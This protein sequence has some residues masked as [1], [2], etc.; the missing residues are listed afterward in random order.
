MKLLCLA[1]CLL[2]AAGSSAFA[3]LTGTNPLVR[4]HTDLGDMDVYLVQ[5]VAP[6]TVTNFLK[7]VNRGDYNNTF[8][9]RS[10]PMFVIQGGG[11]TFANGQPVA[12]RQ[13]AAIQNEFHI[14][15]TRGTV[16]MAK[17]AGNPNSA[18][19]QWFFNESDSNASGPDG[20]DTQNGGFT[21]FGRLMTSAG[22]TT[23]DTIAAVSIHPTCPFQSPLHLWEYGDGLESRPRDLDQGHAAGCRNY[24]SVRE[25][26]SHPGPRGKQHQLHPAKIS[27]A[28]RIRLHHLG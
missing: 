3:Q 15:N 7:Y 19:N 5:D 13:D 17:Q 11:Y 20:L 9:H 4:F 12:I 8:I 23:M 21:V 27:Y 24:S 26:H 6:I 28:G 14:S 25:H 1:L 18:T 10:A 22:L 16:A 2:L